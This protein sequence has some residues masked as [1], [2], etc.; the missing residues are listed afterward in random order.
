MPFSRL[1][2]PPPVVKGVRAAG[3]TEPT[4]IQHRAIPII[5]APSAEP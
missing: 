3:Y 1:G 2:L 4:P 5:L